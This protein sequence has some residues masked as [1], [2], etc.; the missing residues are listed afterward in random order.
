MN[1]ECVPVSF[2]M[3]RSLWD[4]HALLKT[5][6]EM[7]QMPQMIITQNK[8]LVSSP[9]FADTSVFTAA[10]DNHSKQKSLLF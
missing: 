1:D 8:K 5:P 2:R 7:P 10:N 9:F 3:Q 4:R 6:F